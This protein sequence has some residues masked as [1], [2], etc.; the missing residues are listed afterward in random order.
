MPDKKTPGVA[1][2]DPDSFF[3]RASPEETGHTPEIVREQVTSLETTE[4]G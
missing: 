2:R 1:N 4:A 3:H